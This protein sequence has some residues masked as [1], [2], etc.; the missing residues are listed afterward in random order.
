MFAIGFWAYEKLNPALRDGLRPIRELNPDSL[1]SWCKKRRGVQPYTLNRPYR[2][3]RY[4]CTDGPGTC[5]QMDQV[6]MCTD[7]PFVNGLLFPSSLEY[8]SSVETTTNQTEKATDIQ[9][10]RY[11]SSSIETAVPI[12]AYRWSTSN[13]H[14]EI[15]DED[16]EDCRPSDC[17]S[18][19]YRCHRETG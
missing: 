14:V 2:M 15:L 6:H 5:A 13:D 11:V 7:E 1:G 10:M 4:M 17:D 16:D 8:R 18:H 9:Y 12:L 19:T 3:T